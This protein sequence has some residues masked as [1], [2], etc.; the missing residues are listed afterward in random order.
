MPMGRGD[1]RHAKGYCDILP[2]P[3]CFPATVLGAD[4][5]RSTFSGIFDLAVRCSHAEF[6]SFRRAFIGQDTIHPFPT[7][8]SRFTG[9]YIRLSSDSGASPTTKNSPSPSFHSLTAVPAV[10]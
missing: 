9:P 3:S 7:I 4:P 2:A 1:G 8:R 6:Y 5:R 10:L